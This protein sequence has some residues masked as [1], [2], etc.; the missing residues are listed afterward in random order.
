MRI[1]LVEDDGLLGE[2]I[3]TGLKQQNYNVDW[4]QQGKQALESIEYE[5][6]DAMVLDLGLPDIGGLE[7]L[8]R[9]RQQGS[10]L[11]VLILTAM[12]SVE[13]RIAGL[14]AGADDYLSKPFDLD[15]VY[16]RIRALIRRGSG[17][18][19]PLINYNDIQ[20]DPA[21]HRVSKDGQ[22]VDLSRREYD[23]LLELLE[24]TGRVLSRA[25]LEEGLYSIDEEM[26]SN[27]VEVHIHH[28]RKKLGSKL[29]RTIRGVGY[30]VDKL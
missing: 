20:L 9:I 15:E 4:F 1:I 13:D 5:S 18:A 6:F 3:V 27:A 7:V 11:P 30:T 21:A 23:V 22:E 12:D 10:L 2:G 16:A 25:R 24:N 8:R 28:L 14:D 29:I 19:N 17:R 26:A